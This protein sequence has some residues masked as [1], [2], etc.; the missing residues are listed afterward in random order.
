MLT[1]VVVVVVVV[2][3]AVFGGVQV[4]VCIRDRGDGDVCGRAGCGGGR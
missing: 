2:V 1:C 4:V 3:V